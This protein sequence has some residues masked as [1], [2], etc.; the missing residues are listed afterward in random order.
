MLIKLKWIY[1]VKTDE[2]GGVLKNKARLVAQ[3]FR[4]EEGIDF[5]E[6][7]APVARIEA[8]C[9]FVSNAAYRN[10]TI[11][12]MDVKTD[13]LNG[14]IKE[15]VPTV[16]GVGLHAV[17]SHIGNHPKDGFTPLE[18]IRRLLA[19]IG[20]R[21]HSGFEGEAFKPERRNKIIPSDYPELL[22]SANKLDK[23]SFK[24]KVPLHLEMD[25]LYDQIATYPCIVQTFLDPILYLAGLKTTWEHSPKRPV[26]YHRGQEMDFRSFMLEG[27]DGEF[28]FL[29][30]EGVSE[31]QNS[32][33]AKFVNNDAPSYGE[34]K[35]T[36]VGLSL[37]PHPEAS[38]KLK[39]LGVRY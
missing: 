32:P 4:Q 31:G 39:I 5:E 22:L 16:K 34:D 33:S 15:E 38:K 18:T 3:G 25:P 2:F 17:D 10:M 13:F 20:R 6:S 24:D 28:N 11:Y 8:I 21:S 35:Q 23:K 26:I 30:A 7:F 36:L 19:V 14:E 1:K 9:I 27:V 12:Q 37:P 29:P